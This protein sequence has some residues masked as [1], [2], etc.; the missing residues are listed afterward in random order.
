MMSVY[1]GNGVIPTTFDIANFP[2]PQHPVAVEV[3]RQYRIVVRAFYTH[4]VAN[5]QQSAPWEHIW[6]TALKTLE[7]HVKERK[8]Q[9][10][11]ANY[12]EKFSTDFAPYA[13][14]ERY[15]DIE[16]AL[17]DKADVPSIRSQVTALRHRFCLLMLTS[18]I[19]RCESLSG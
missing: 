9:V 19:L 5:K 15:S 13:I 4:Q 18:G 6:Q 12:C 17:F 10:R 14:V 2:L 3:W 16:A 8:A 7:K 1:I 11:R